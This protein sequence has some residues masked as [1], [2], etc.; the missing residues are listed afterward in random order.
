MKGFVRC[1]FVLDMGW[2]KGDVKF[3]VY[4]RK[5]KMKGVM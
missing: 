3:K 2:M 4:L 1:A 5:E